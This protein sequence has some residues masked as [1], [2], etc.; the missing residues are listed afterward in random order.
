MT[1]FSYQSILVVDV[2]DSRSENGRISAPGRKMEKVKALCILQFQKLKKANCLQFFDFWTRSGVMT[3]FSYQSLLVV[4]VIASRSENGYKSV[5]GQ[6]MEK[7]EVLC[8]LQL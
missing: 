5:P 3:V 6:K 4:D 8:L 7:G 1:V 2:I